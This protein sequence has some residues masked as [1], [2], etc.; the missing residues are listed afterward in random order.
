MRRLGRTEAHSPPQGDL[1][2][3][4][5]VLPPHDREDAPVLA[6]GSA[7][8]HRGRTSIGPQ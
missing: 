7:P 3:C 6:E 8:T 1:R 4:A 2:P 5:R